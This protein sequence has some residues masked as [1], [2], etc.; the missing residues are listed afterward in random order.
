MH[1]SPAQ[2]QNANPGPT[3]AAWISKDQRPA[4]TAV[5]TVPSRTST[6]WLLTSLPAPHRP[7]KCESRGRRKPH[8]PMGRV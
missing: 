3:D 1:L 7:E 2:P 5:R 6:S 8:Q 4:Q